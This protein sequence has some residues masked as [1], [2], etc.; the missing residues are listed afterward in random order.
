MSNSIHPAAP[1]GQDGVVR[2]ALP[3]PLKLY[4]LLPAGLVVGFLFSAPWK[5]A[6]KRVDRLTPVLAAGLL[7]VIL[8]ALYRPWR[9]ALRAALLDRSP[10]FGWRTPLLLFVGSALFLFRVVLSRYDGLEVNAWDFSVYEFA[11]RGWGTA[12]V[13]FSPLEGRS[14]LGTHASYLLFV[15]PLLYAM[16][17]THLWLMAAHVAAI[18]GAVVVAFAVC[19][20]ILQDD[21]ASRLVAIAFLLNTYTAKMVQYVFHAEVFYPV[22]LFLTALGVVRKKPA[23]F[24]AGVLLT[25]LVKEDAVLALLGICSAGLI[26]DKCLWR[27]WLAGAAIAVAA[28]SIGSFLVIPHFAATVPGQPWYTPLWGAYGPT[29]LQA[30]VGMLRH[31][32]TVAGDVG[33]SGV[34]GLLETLGFLPLAGYEWLVAALPALMVYG[35]SNGGRGGLAQFSIYYSAAVL[36]LLLLAAAKGL[37][38]ISAWSRSGA[39]R[40]RALRLG[41]IAILFV[42][43]LDGASY[44]FF[45]PKPSRLDIASLG[46]PANTRLRVQGALLPHMRLNAR[47]VPLTSLTIESP[48]AETILLDLDANPYPFSAEALRDYARRLQASGFQVHRTPHGLLVVSPPVPK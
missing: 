47:A 42:S 32:L 25:V 18:A 3:W 41:A 35:A 12:T 24:L 34:V 8:A 15:F 19:R 17:N 7:L 48:S 36:P 11:V 22:C 45:F 9:G 46:F 39:G 28:F 14:Q 38:R 29:P 31:P 5:L 20:R 23:V 6:G 43:A 13:L 21:L 2:T 1:H 26:L 37:A 33:R 40:R 10:I 16:W 44:V 27:W 4:L 30:A